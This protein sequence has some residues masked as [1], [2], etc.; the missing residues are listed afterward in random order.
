MSKSL[1]Q[2]PTVALVGISGYGGIHLQLLRERARLGQLRLASV[3]A[4]DAGPSGRESA[5]AAELRNAGCTVHSSLESLLAA[6]N[7]VPDL[8]VL[9]TPI[10]L[11]RA[12]TEQALRAGS[13]VLVE[14]PLAGGLADAEA[15]VSA[16]ER[17]RR[18]V[19][20][21]FQELH[22][23]EVLALK[24]LLVE[25]AIGRLQRISTCVRWPRDSHYYARNAWA[26]R[27]RLGT[28]L[29]RDSPLNNAMAHFLMLGLFFAGETVGEACTATRL[30]AELYRAQP[31][32]SFDTAD[33]WLE[34]RR[35]VSVRCLVTHSSAQE[36]QA[37]LR[38]EGEHGFALWRQQGDCEWTG[39]DGVRHVIATRQLH[40]GR[41]HIL[42]AVLEHLRQPSRFICGPKLALAHTRVIEALHL[43]A[44]IH[45]VAEHFL[46]RESRPG[47]RVQTLISDLDARLDVAAAAGLPLHASGASWTHPATQ[48]ELAS[49]KPS[50]ELSELPPMLA[51]A[52]NLLASG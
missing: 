2:P 10:H 46:R 33:V 35:G 30:T 34:D 45:T 49:G 36:T 12:M 16:A 9:P 4:I 28:E 23:P 24:Q 25:G 7:R 13:H 19:V 26:G 14:K 42:D 1:S 17:H 20:V 38:I 18:T 41:D 39:A 27:V 5:L 31:I 37:E 32:E 29:L 6:P 50:P 52:E 47:A 21:G 40:D 8:V 3:V 15:I 11:H 22:A 48:V 51:S 44:P 43:H